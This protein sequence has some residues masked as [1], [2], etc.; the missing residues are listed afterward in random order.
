MTL[1]GYSSTSW[2]CAF[3]FAT[4]SPAAGRRTDRWTAM[5]HSDID[6]VDRWRWR[7]RGYSPRA[8]KKSGPTGHPDDWWGVTGPRSSTASSVVST[9]KKGKKLGEVEVVGAKWIKLCAHLWNAEH[10]WFGKQR[11]RAAG[12][13]QS[14]SFASLSAGGI[15]VDCALSSSGRF[16][17]CGDC[18]SRSVASLRVGWCWSVLRRCVGW[19]IFLLLKFELNLAWEQFFVWIL[20][21]LNLAW[22]AVWL[23]C[24]RNFR[25]E[26][27][28]QFQISNECLAESR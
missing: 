5:G 8:D 11:K 18:R 3:M 1:N 28:F 7:D 21:I 19:S 13:R 16:H 14:W 10:G 23:M 17:S 9:N 27:Y 26:F 2:S 12:E 25:S 15:V 4:P 6:G 22:R 20:K 24:D